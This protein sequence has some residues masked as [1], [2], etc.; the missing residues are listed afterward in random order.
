MLPL[1]IIVFSQLFSIVI[2]AKF[3][4]RECTYRHDKTRCIDPDY[5]SPGCGLPNRLPGGFH[6]RRKRIV[7]GRNSRPNEFPWIVNVQVKSG[8]KS[9]TPHCGGTLITNV[10][11]LTAAQCISGKD[12]VDFRMVLGDHH[13]TE[14]DSSER[15]R[16]AKWI[17]THPEYTPEPFVND[18]GLIQ[19]KEPVNFDEFVRPVCLPVQRKCM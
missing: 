9:W 12:P 14:V 4:F 13:L 6:R 10:H 2:P 16:L 18:I 8:S 5:L 11:V 17:R 3:S 15:T 1:K 19:M 7:G